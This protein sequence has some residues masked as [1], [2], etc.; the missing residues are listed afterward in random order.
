L[1]VKLQIILLVLVDGQDVLAGLEA[2]GHN[3]T[4]R[5]TYISVVNSIRIKCASDKDGE[6]P[7]QMEKCVEA[8]ADGRR[9][10]FGVQ[11][12]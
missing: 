3:A 8:V 1:S 9:G 6:D 7:Y 12:I 10:N 11:G 2:K 5:K 4:E